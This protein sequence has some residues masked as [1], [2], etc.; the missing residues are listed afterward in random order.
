MK[1]FLIGLLVVALAIGGTFFYRDY[2][3]KRKFRK[4]SEQ[5]YKTIAPLMIKVTAQ[6]EVAES[7]FLKAAGDPSLRHAL[8][9]ALSACQRGDLFPTAYLTIEK[10]AE[11]SL[12]NWLEFP[13]ELGAAPDEIEFIEMITVQDDGDLHY[14]VFRYRMVT[15]HWAKKFGW[16]IG[17]AGPYKK[18][19]LPYDIPRR[20]FSRFNIAE[21]T[22][23]V[24]EVEWVH[25]NVNRG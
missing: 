17:V 23:I 5:K 2:Y 16:M 13:T 24:G 8:F 10:G 21:S 18:D 9:S 1:S 15:P 4:L 7:E 25:A 22:P 11:S 20:V 3:L 6:V 14:Y 12:V 19:S